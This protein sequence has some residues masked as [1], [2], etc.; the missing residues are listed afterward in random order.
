MLKIIQLVLVCLSL[1]LPR[2]VSAAERHIHSSAGL[3]GSG[4]P[5]YVA[6]SGGIFE[7][8]GLDVDLLV[9]PGGPLGMQTLL[10]GSTHSANIAAMT[11]IRTSLAGGDIVIVGGYL[12]RQMFNLITRKEIRKPGDLQGK[13]I[14]V[15]SLAGTNAVAIRLVLRE[16]KIP[17]E[18]VH[19]LVIGGSPT[20]L[21]ALEAGTI[22]ACVL[23]YGVTPEAVRKGMT[24]LAD[25]AKPVPEFPDRTIMMRRSFLKKER[26]NARRFMQAVSEAIYL[27]K[28][29]DNRRREE[30]I[31]IAGK[32]LRVN[33]TAAR[34][35]YTQYENVFS[36]PPRVGRKGMAA[37]IELMQEETGRP[38]AEFELHRF[39]DESILDEL[40]K[41]GF[42]K[43]L[44]SE[45]ARK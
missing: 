28:T 17:T 31:A 44:E 4:L 23:S 42:F 12:N 22:D 21:A 13:K 7:K 14:G 30:L 16:W 10:S 38:K 45:Y 34:E 20:Q 35:F 40:E 8:Y 43:K 26:D 5:L 29:A 15:A 32:H 18:A 19:L 3:G 11:P 2:L 37:V 9:I 1:T 24:V 39:L 41:E 25:L 33:P 27:I 6:K 36:F